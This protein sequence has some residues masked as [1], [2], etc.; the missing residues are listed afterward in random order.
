[1]AEAENK[2]E[3]QL[4][5]LVDQNLLDEDVSILEAF[6]NLE[7]DDEGYVID[8]FF[9]RTKVMLSAPAENQ[10]CFKRECL[11]EVDNEEDERI[12]AEIFSPRQG[13]NKA[14]TQNGSVVLQAQ[15]PPSKKAKGENASAMPLMLGSGFFIPDAKFKRKDVLETYKSPNGGILGKLRKT[16]CILTAAHCVM[17][18][19]GELADK[20]A[21]Y[22]INPKKYESARVNEET[23]SKA[24]NTGDRFDRITTKV[25]KVNEN[26]SLKKPEKWVKK[27]LGYTKVYV[28]PQYI[29]DNKLAGSDIALI[30]LSKPVQAVFS[31]IH[32]VI[33][34]ETKPDDVKYTCVTGYPGEDE[35]SYL[36]Y[37]SGGFKEKG[38]RC[39]K[40]IQFSE[41]HLQLGKPIGAIQYNCQ[42]TMGQSGGCVKLDLGN[43]QY[44]VGAIHNHGEQVETQDGIKLGTGDNWGS[45]ITTYVLEWIQEKQTG[46]KKGAWWRFGF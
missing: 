8:E 41:T 26:S 30:V 32:A 18:T 2:T 33:G 16:R 28:L 36:L 13:Y 24:G 29:Q 1:M 11:N 20:L 37:K 23:E 34:P 17:N 46:K 21:I 15:F 25:R 3:N 44:T 19:S 31:D 27:Q 9:G 22:V 6:G 38:D 14:F 12:L 43:H 5:D 7:K 35:K 4:N 10:T 39:T 45:L 42:T 40:Q